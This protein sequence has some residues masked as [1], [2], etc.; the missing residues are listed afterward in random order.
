M[1]LENRVKIRGVINKNVRSSNF[2]RNIFEVFE[3]F[4][5]LFGALKLNFEEKQELLGS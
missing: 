1:T 4:R 3:N 2:F 5:G